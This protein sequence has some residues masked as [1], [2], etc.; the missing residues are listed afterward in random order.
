MIRPAGSFALVAMLLLCVPASLNARLEQPEP[1][2]GAE[3]AAP[4]SDDGWNFDDETEDAASRWSETLRPQL[5]DLG[6]FAAFLALAITSFFRKS[7]QPELANYAY[8]V[9]VD[10]FPAHEKAPLVLYTLAQTKKHTAP[11]ESNETVGSHP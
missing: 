6:L 10:N 9:F 7:D 5:L 11:A 8:E 3:A 4:A 1:T 2:A